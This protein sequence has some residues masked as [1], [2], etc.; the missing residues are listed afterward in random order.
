MHWYVFFCLETKRKKL[1]GQ[2]KIRKKFIADLTPYVPGSSI[3]QK[4]SSNHLSPA[5][6]SNSPPGERG[7][8]TFQERPPQLYPGKYLNS[9]VREHGRTTEKSWGETAL[10]G[11]QSDAPVHHP[12]THLPHILHRSTFDLPFQSLPI[13]Y[14]PPSIYRVIIFPSSP[15]LSIYSQNLPLMHSSVQPTVQLTICPSILLAHYPFIYPPL[16][17]HE[18]TTHPSPIIH[19]PNC[20]C[21]TFLPITTHTH[22]LT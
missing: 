5:S 21:P 22:I 9:K 8:V 3:P 19:L 1:D 11:A 12:L 2:D 18:P 17:T 14:H 20:S 6:R 7:V 13:F 10:L 4:V 16:G 15:P